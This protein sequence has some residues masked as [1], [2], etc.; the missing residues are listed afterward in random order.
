MARELLIGKLGFGKD[1]AFYGLEL[2]LSI[3]GKSAVSVTPQ[4]ARSVNVLLVT[5]FWYRDVYRLASFFRKAGIYKG[6]KDGPLI[7]IGGM[8]ATMNPRLVAEFCDFVFIGDAD[9]ALG[10]IIEQIEAGDNPVHDHLITSESAEIPLPR[11]CP[12][13]AFA[14]NK[15]GAMDVVRI[16]IAR[17]CRFKCSFCALS[18]MKQ[19]REVPIDAI[20]TILEACK[21]KTISLFAP[22]RSMHADWPKLEEWMTAHKKRDLGQDAR[23]ENIHKIKKSS[24][25]FGLEGISERLRKSIKK[26]YSEDFIIQKLGDFI[27]Q[28]G[29]ICM[30][31]AY[32][33]ADLPGEND[34]D[35]EELW[36]LFERIESEH[37]SRFMT[38]KPVLNP[39]S[40][41]P[42]TGLRDAEV[43]PFRDY[44]TKWKHILRKGGNSQ[45]GFRCVE[46]LVWGPMQRV[47]DAIA[48][49][50]GPEAAQL[51]RSMSNPLLDQRI[52]LKDQHLVARK[53]IQKAVEAGCT[54]AQLFGPRSH[55]R[56]TT[57]PTAPA[58]NLGHLAGQGATHRAVA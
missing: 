7:I 25:T 36:R 57:S 40:P 43:H 20:I 18:G 33:I 21:S 39:L 49:W 10:G 54:E 51:I 30:I 15:G 6:M 26:N 47:M 13:S 44:R 55:A 28:Q 17:G 9:D 3:A 45:W 48:T 5:L 11:E 42:F 2:C 38:F 27:E 1:D 12:P 37:F 34:S 53:L 50:G 32:F 8:H 24:V 35:W 46:S 4:T 52:Q 56:T 31:S 29:R 58:S 14:M 22:D 23:L 41:K 16:E 19:Y